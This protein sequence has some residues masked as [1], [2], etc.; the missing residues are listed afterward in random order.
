MAK[1]QE[2]AEVDPRAPVESTWGG[3]VKWDCPFCP[4]DS[5]DRARGRGAYRERASSAITERDLMRLRPRTTCRRRSQSL[6][7]N[8]RPRL[9]PN[10]RPPSVAPKSSP[11]QKPTEP[12]TETGPVIGPDETKQPAVP[13]EN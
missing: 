3:L 10:R 8:H 4:R 2:E 7:L 1:K 11:V 6:H 13:E 12:I 5:F 9:F